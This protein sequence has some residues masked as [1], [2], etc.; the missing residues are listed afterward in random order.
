LQER[1]KLINS[2]VSDKSD[3]N[4]VSIRKSEKPASLLPRARPAAN[5]KMLC[6]DR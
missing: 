2:L 6:R 4:Q 1:K 5:T 3:E